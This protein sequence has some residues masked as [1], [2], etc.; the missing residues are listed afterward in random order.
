MTEVFSLLGRWLREPLVHFLALGTLLFLAYSWVEGGRD[1]SNRIVVTRGQIDALAATF[2]RTWQRPPTE[3]ELK[4]QI[5]D[6]VRE[7][8]ATRE[9]LA[10]GLDRDDV[11][12][13]RRLRQKLESLLVDITLDTSAPGDAELQA[14]LD[15]RAD[16]FRREP[17]IAFRQIYLSPKKRGASVTEDALA[18]REQLAKVTAGA[19]MNQLGDTSMLPGDLPLSPVSDVGRLFGQDFIRELVKLEPGRWAGP[20]TSSY[21]LH[22]VFVRERVAG[23]MPRLAEVRPQVER[24]F[25]AGRRQR[26][27]DEMYRELLKRYQVSIE[28]Q[29]ASERLSP[30]AAP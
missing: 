4:A 21:G 20:V 15:V 25:A 12:V 29:R 30:T 1:V 9:A 2:A 7:E 16:Q 17:E 11:I 22:L 8:I 13:R 3:Q 28:S 10:G 26:Q 5:D 24:D 19:G 18:L 6:F 14:W 27:V 23:R